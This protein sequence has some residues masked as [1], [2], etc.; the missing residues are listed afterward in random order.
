MN[1]LYYLVGTKEIKKVKIRL[2]HNDLQ[3]IESTELLCKSDNWNS[4]LRKYKNNDLLNEKLRLLRE[5][6]IDSFS[7]DFASGV[8]INKEWL[9]DIIKESFGRPNAEKKLVNQSHTVFLEDFANHWLKNHAN[10]W[11]DLNGN[12]MTDKAKSQKTKALAEFVEFQSKKAQSKIKLKDFT[13]ERIKGFYTFLTKK[14]FA[15]STSRKTISYIFFFCQMA[16]EMKFNV[17]LDFK[18]KIVFN[19]KSTKVE[20]IYLNEAEIETIFNHDFSDDEFL[21]T[22]RDNFIL[23]L[24]SGK[25]ISD[26]RNLT[27]ANIVNGMIESIDKKTKTLVKLPLFTQTKAILEKRSGLP[28]RV[29]KN[30]YNI[31]IK[32]VCRL[33]GIDGMTL[34]NIK[35]NGSKVKVLAYYEKYKLVTSHTARRSFATNLC[36]H[37]P[38]ETVA[39]IGGWKSTRMVLHYNK[40]TKAETVERV[41]EKFKTIAV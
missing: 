21:D 13:T 41:L 2:Y 36:K 24:W 6:V 4:E 9:Q 23:N 18:D 11:E 32:E 34:G 33:C 7:I 28:P 17:C 8:I 26:L 20:D 12:L 19:D 31:E 25:R 1:V 3:L 39:V 27:S 38:P 22:V 29:S 15:H 5:A 40:E 16:K 10:T 30:R 14:G 37:F 35:S